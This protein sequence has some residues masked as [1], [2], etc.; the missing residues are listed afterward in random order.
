MRMSE[1]DMDRYF[2]WVTGLQP[3][4]RVL[5]AGA[6]VVGLLA[7]ATGLATDNVVFLLLGGV[8]IVGMGGIAL[9]AS[10]FD[11]DSDERS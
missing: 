5:V 10:K 9:L 2:E 4:Y 6:L 7:L 11:P 8:W 3:F 1:L